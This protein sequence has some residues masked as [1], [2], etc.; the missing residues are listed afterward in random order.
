MSTA[1]QPR[2]EALCVFDLPKDVRDAAK[3]GLLKPSKSVFGGRRENPGQAEAGEKG[4]A[5]AAAV[6]TAT[7]DGALS[8]GGIGRLEVSSSMS[9]STC[10]ASFADKESQ[11]EHYKLDWHRFNLKQALQ[12]RAT[13]GEEAFEKM[14]EDGGGDDMSLSGSD[15]TSDEEEE[16]GE[17]GGDDGMEEMLRR[18]RHPWFFLEDDRGELMSVHKCVVDR[19]SGGKK[20]EEEVQEQE[21]I[22]EEMMSTFLDLCKG[23]GG[24]WAVFMLGGG[25]FAGA[26]F[27]GREPMVHKTFHCYTVRAK[28]GGSQSSKDSKGGGGNHPKSAGASLRRYNEASLLQHVRDIVSTWS[29]HLAGCHR[30]FYRAASGNRAV[31][32][33]GRDPPLQRA[34]PRLRSIPFPTRRATYAEVRR[35]HAVLSS[36]RLHGD[37]RAYAEGEEAHRRKGEAAEQQLQPS[38]S[39]RRKSKAGDKPGSS[40]PSKRTQQIRRSKSREVVERSL[41]EE[42]QHLL[43]ESPS[44]SASDEEEEDE[45]RLNL[46]TFVSGTSHLSEF[47]NTPVPNKGK[48]NKKR[49]IRPVPPGGGEEGADDLDGDWSP[50]LDSRLVTACKSGNAGELAKIMEEIKGDEAERGDLAEVLNRQHGN[51][52]VT[53]LHLA[54]S[55]GHRPVVRALLRAGA[56][57]CARDSSRRVPYQLCPDKETRSTFRAF[58]GEFPEGVDWTRAQVPP[59][60]SEEDEARQREKKARQRQARKEKA[61]TKKVEDEK[62]RAEQAEKERYLALS[63]R[64]KRAMAAERRI[65]EQTGGG[66]GGGGEMNKPVLSRCFQ[67]AADITGKVPF[68]YLNFVFCSPKCVREHRQKNRTSQ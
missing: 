59:P 3:G 42:I 36:L 14:L 54:A 48:R 63:D 64:E 45:G 40:S 62:G 13:V 46:E 18:Q 68:E 51:S 27:Q 37:A 30:V 28:Q 9:C 33:G 7:A 25:H 66:A 19:R 47:G 23:V 21:A 31:L 56:D 12:G 49:P 17:V 5:P 60:P 50:L 34:D 24:R 4:S 35:V 55:S 67:C 65:L 53:L 43:V 15:E 32:F 16:E 57:P 22:E 8:G 61:R 10:Q 39:R 58:R 6:A 41:P 11:R 20:W 44:Q 38:P 29:D 2:V 26:V 52:K 1:R